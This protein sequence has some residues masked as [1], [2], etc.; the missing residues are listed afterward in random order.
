MMYQHHF[1]PSA[2]QRPTIPTHRFK[3]TNIWG[4]EQTKLGQKLLWAQ[5]WRP[6]TVS[7]DNEAGIPLTNQLLDPLQK[8]YAWLLIEPL[9]CHAFDIF[10]LLK[11]TTL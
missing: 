6:H 9:Q 10:I 5:E 1:L 2:L 4:V 3:L 11:S 8:E 7:T